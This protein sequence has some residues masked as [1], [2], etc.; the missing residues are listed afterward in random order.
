MSASDHLSNEL[1]HSVHRGLVAKEGVDKSALG[2]HWS[3]EPKVAFRFATEGNRWPSKEEAKSKKI[4]HAEVPMS[5]VETNTTQM[6][7]R[8]YGSFPGPN[9]LDEQEVMVKEGAPVKLTGMTSLR[10]SKDETLKGRKR[11]YN[12]PREMKA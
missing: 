6:Q 11:T 9:K 4:L 7:K 10:L 8:G 5:S 12:P 2:V 1:F 3:V